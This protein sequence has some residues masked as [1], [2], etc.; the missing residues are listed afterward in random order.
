MLQKLPYCERQ[1][2]KTKNSNYGIFYAVNILVH[3]F[4]QVSLKICKSELNFQSIL[5]L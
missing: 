5:S 1:K 2:N 4:G 3:I